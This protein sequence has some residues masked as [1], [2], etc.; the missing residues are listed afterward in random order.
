MTLETGLQTCCDRAMKKFQFFAALSLVSLFCALFASSAFCRDEPM[1]YLGGLFGV[2]SP[3]NGDAQ[4]AY[5][6]TLGRRLTPDFGIGAYVTTSKQSDTMADNRVSTYG[7]QGDYYFTG[8]MDGLVLGVKFG[9][10][11]L[12]STMA[13]GSSVSSTP[14]S[15]GPRLGFDY[16]LVPGFSIGFEGDVLFQGSNK[17]IDGYT[18]INML[19]AVK[20]WF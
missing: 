14:L 3:S 9:L 5:G 15:I 4:F 18:L 13:N 6:A 2:A 1:T 17:N 19:G 16:R 20:L 7:V 12:K 10:A 8:D 11:T